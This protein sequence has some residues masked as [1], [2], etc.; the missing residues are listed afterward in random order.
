M[1]YYFFLSAFSYDVFEH[2]DAQVLRRTDRDVV[3]DI[4]TYPG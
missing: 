1:L 2:V 4:R 3:F